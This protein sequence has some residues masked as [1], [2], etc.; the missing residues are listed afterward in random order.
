MWVEVLFSAI[1]VFSAVIIAYLQK[2]YCANLRSV[3]RFGP[4]ET[5]SVIEMRGIFRYNA[6]M[7]KK[8]R[9]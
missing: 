6:F 3:L 4:A 2:K 8:G 1:F 7:K 5:V 9:A